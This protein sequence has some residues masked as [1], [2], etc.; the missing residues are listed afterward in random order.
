M[1]TTDINF[2]AGLRG[3]LRETH[4]MTP[5]QPFMR[6]QMASG[7]ARQ[8]RLFQNVPTVASFSWI[9]ND[10]EALIFEAWFR[11]EIHDGTD[12]FNVNYRLP[13][14][15]R[16]VVARFTQMYQGPNLTALNHHGYSAQL[17]FYERPI[18]LPPPWGQFPDFIRYANII[19][20]AV[21]REWPEA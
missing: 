11:D 19:D 2:P 16:S 5:V 18:A 14:G 10:T 17:E 12:W 20:L 21:N 1:I 15:V 4:T 7:R 9:F 6:T 3:P 13:G 8:R